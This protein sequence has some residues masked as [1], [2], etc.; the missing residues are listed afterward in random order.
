MAGFFGCQASRILNSLRAVFDAI[1]IL[2]VIM[3]MKKKTG[4]K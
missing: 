2:Y 3:K 4:I 1:Y